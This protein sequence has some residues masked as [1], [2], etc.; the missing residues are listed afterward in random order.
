[1]Q[2]RLAIGRGVKVLVQK[3]RGGRGVKEPTLPV[4]GL[5]YYT[6]NIHNIKEIQVSQQAHRQKGRAVQTRQQTRNYD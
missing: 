4:E 6:I 2:K 3:N 5:N 1:M